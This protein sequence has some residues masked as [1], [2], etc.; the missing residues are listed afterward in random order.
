METE[1]AA[2]QREMEH[3]NRQGVRLEDYKGRLDMD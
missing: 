1:A 2:K 3:H